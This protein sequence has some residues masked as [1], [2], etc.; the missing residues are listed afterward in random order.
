MAIVLLV[1][2]LLVVVGLFPVVIDMWVDSFGQRA[3]FVARVGYRA[4]EDEKA[5]EREARKGEK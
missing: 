2:L 4:V 3:N 5:R 1:L